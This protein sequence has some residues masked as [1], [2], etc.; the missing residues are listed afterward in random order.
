MKLSVLIV[1]Y[2]QAPFI[3]Q[4]VRS[5]LMQETAFDY[6]IVVADDCSTDGTRQI[7][8]HLAERHPDRLRLVAHETHVDVQQNLLDGYAS[9]DGQY[10]AL[11]DG[12][13]YWISPYKL[14]RQVNFLDRHAEC[15]ISFHNIL[16]VYDDGSP[17]ALACSADR[18]EFS[19][20]E[21]LL[22]ANFIP[23]SSVVYRHGL[24]REFPQWSRTLMTWDWALHLFHAQFGR[25]GYLADTMAVGRRHAGGLWTGASPRARI[26]A[27]IA[28]LKHLNRQFSG[29]YDAVIRASIGRWES[30]GKLEDL[31]LTFKRLEAEWQRQLEEVQLDRSSAVNEIRAQL[32]ESVR[33]REHLARE[34]ERISRDKERIAT[35]KELALRQIAELRRVAEDQRLALDNLRA[36]IEL[37]VSREE[38]VSSETL[39]GL[40]MVDHQLGEIHRWVDVQRTRELVQTV[41]PPGA[42]VLI[43]SRGDAELLG[44]NGRIGWHFPQTEGGTYAGAHPVDSSEATLHLEA[45]RMRGAQYL[46]FPGSS[47]WWLDHYTEF[48]RHLE[49]HYRAVL[50]RDGSCVIFAIETR[51]GDTAAPDR[52]EGPADVA[53]P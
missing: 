17:E 19:G 45:L 21:D 6:Q 29:K 46:A 4:A 9:C 38:I 24:I 41:V 50:R 22:I 13:D 25:A 8:E 52:V 33:D 27:T 20:V 49:K 2:N 43:V 31:H 47:L 15:A 12:D 28:M 42:T 51:T 34:V 40:S 44:L 7:V 36:A 11:L 48:R 16:T 10:L 35:E 30:V 32:R 5:A 14:Q 18:K 39:R 3:E 53:V 1:A 37:N 23:T 26:Q